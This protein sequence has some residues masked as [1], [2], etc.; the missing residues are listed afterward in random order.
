MVRLKKKRN[1]AEAKH[2]FFLIN[3]FHTNMKKLVFGEITLI[4][5]KINQLC[6]QSARLMHDRQD[7]SFVKICFLCSG[8]SPS[9]SARTTRCPSCAM[10]SQVSVTTS[11]PSCLVIGSLTKEAPLL[12]TTTLP[13]SIHPSSIC[14]CL[15]L[16]Q[17]Y[18][19]FKI[20]IILFRI[21]IH[22]YLIHSPCFSTL[23]F[24]SSTSL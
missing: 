6:M 17:L 14:S 4:H 10:T 2:T 22:S 16:W 23:L 12:L 18:A 9:V 20:C 8:S 24:A 21:L 3:I 1:S 7:F 11:P 15:I 5:S 13:F 19:R